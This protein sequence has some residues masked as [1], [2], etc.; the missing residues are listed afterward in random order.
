M[1]SPF[2]PLASK[3]IVSP[4]VAQLPDT[5]PDNSEFGGWAIPLDHHIAEFVVVNL[6]GAWA[7]WW[8]LRKLSLRKTWKSIN[9]GTRS[10]LQRADYI[11]LASLV[12]SYALM[13]WHKYN[14][15]QL[16]F[17]LQPCHCL[18]I[19]LM[20]TIVIGN[21]FVGTIL[22]N[23]F[24]H[25]MFSAFLGLVAADLTCYEQPLELENWFIQHVL[26]NVLPLFYIYQQVSTS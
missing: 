20:I 24:L 2:K 5:C 7:F 6:F 22:F 14:D 8:S 9:R 15:N 4:W 21:G 3:L 10:K 11:I 17:L 13:F 12:A 16:W 23:I 19:M 26:L 18:H 1:K 25:L